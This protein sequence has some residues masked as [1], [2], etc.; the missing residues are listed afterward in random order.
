MVYMHFAS[1]L[2][3]IAA[4]G[5]L[6]WLSL[7]SGPWPWLPFV[8]LTPFALTLRN[9]GPVGGLF[10]GWAGGALIWLMS[11]SWVFN[12]FQHLM[13]WS[14]VL[15]VAGTL[16]FALVQGLPYAIF[17]LVCGV[18][19][20]RGRPVGPLFQAAL[21]T[22]L[23][24][25]LPAP[26]P[27]SPALSL[28]SL[29]LAIQIADLGGFALVNFF[30]ILINW[31]LA[32]VL[33]WM[34]RPRKCIPGLIAAGLVLAA[35]LGYGGLRLNH[36]QMLE[37][38]ASRDKF[39]TVRSIQP[40][41]PVVGA[42][43]KKLDDPYKGVLGIMQMLT[44]TTASDFAPAD[45][46]LWPEV[47][48]GIYCNCDF[49]E[50][51]GMNRTTRLANAPIV[52]AC[53]ENPRLRSPEAEKE[54][55]P[56]QPGSSARKHR[57]FTVYNTLMLINA[58][59]CR[60]IYRKHKLVPFG[61]AAPLREKW[62]WLYSKMAKQ[63]EYVP[64]PGPKVFSLPGGPEVQP[65]IC[66]ESGFPK[67]TRTGAAMGAQAFINV[68]NDAWFM[69]A[70]AAEQHL[71]L[72]L[73]RAVEQRRPLVRN[74]NTGFG[75]HIKA[76]GEIVPGSLTPMNKRAV[77]QAAL[78]LPNETTIYQSTGNSWLWLAVVFVL[79]RIGQGHRLWLSQKNQNVS[80]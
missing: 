51:H 12:S 38:H 19:Q 54:Q 34:R 41:I 35:C 67:M 1:R 42:V 28:Y 2:A 43:G 53:L 61:E 37:Q 29:P 46:V 25:I 58:S 6:V 5:F 22:L 16:L 30:F 7:P 26:C 23:V 57:Q 70:R 76:S 78:Y 32:D 64:G 18:L 11:T 52:L 39:L 62:P 44:E 14:V 73:F 69:S 80:H 48:R 31:L 10:W 8:S 15:S 66:F 75:A 72:A 21:L 68:S 47:S 3:G 74:T 40:D 59:Q 56:D 36:F 27:G 63:M 45:L 17:G 9:T 60:I 71:A 55:G 20:S 4:A 79:I 77:R 13:G 49:F 24:F 33:T 50:D 65:L